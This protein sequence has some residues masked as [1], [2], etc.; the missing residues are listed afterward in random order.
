MKKLF[1][2][3]FFIF[4][5]LLADNHAIHCEDFMSESDCVVHAECEWHADEMACEDAGGDHDH[6]DEDGD[7]H[8]DHG[9]EEG[10]YSFELVGLAAGQGIFNISIFHDGHADYTSMP[11]IVTVLE[12]EHCE[13]FMSESDCVVH[14]ECEWHADEMA[15]EDA[16]GDHDHGDDDDHGHGDEEHCEDLLDESSCT[17]L[18]YTS[19][20]A[21]E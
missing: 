2:S 9:H 11:I 15:C 8:D 5:G 6:G 16:A 13:D 18:L 7:D 4:S 3:I 17:C 19:D 21:D 1:I 12:E 14:A 20:A 10:D